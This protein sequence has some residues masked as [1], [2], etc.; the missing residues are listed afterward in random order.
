GPDGLSTATPEATIYR[1]GTGA[2][3]PKGRS[4]APQHVTVSDGTSGRVHLKWQRRPGLA[5]M[6]TYQVVIVDGATETHLLTTNSS[7]VTLTNLNPSSDYTLAV[8]ARNLIGHRSARS[9]LVA[10]VTP[11]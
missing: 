1:S 5:W 3:R 7:S 2:A 10:A 8:Y 9:A 11:P 6:T 4:R